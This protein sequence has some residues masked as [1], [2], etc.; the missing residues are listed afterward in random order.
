MIKRKKRY[1]FADHQEAEILKRVYLRHGADAALIFNWITTSSH[2]IHDSGISEVSCTRI[3]RAVGMDDHQVEE[4]LTLL[5]D[6][7]V[8][9]DFDHE[10]ILL[11]TLAD[12]YVGY[13]AESPKDNR[14]THLQRHLSTLPECPCRQYIEELLNPSNRTEL[15]EELGKPLRKP[16][17]KPLPGRVA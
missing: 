1:V 14:T 3:A 6:F 12:Q 13:L 9:Y 15:K 5:A 4:I 8:D 10:V 17:R 7:G 2:L 11:R 16:L